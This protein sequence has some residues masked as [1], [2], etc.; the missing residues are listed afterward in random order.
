LL[1]FGAFS[2]LLSVSMYATNKPIVAVLP[3]DSYDRNLQSH[4]DALTASVTNALQKRGTVAVVD[5]NSLQ[6]IFAEAKLSMTGIVDGKQA[7]GAGKLQGADY[8]IIGRLYSLS[9]GSMAFVSFGWRLHRVSDGH[10]VYQS[11]ESVKAGRS[12]FLPGLDQVGQ[13]IA[14]AAAKAGELV[15]DKVAETFPIETRIAAVKEFDEGERYAEVVYLPLGP[16]DGLREDQKLW[17]GCESDEF[18]GSVLFFGNMT[19]E[20]F[21]DGLTLAEIKNGEKYVH[22]DS[23]NSTEGTSPYIVRGGFSCL[24]RTDAFSISVLPFSGAADPLFKDALFEIISSKIL[25]CQWFGIPE[26]GKVAEVI[27]ERNLQL[28]GVVAESEL[29]AI[30]QRVGADAV[31]F[32]DVNSYSGGLEKMGGAL[33]FVT[34]FGLTAKLVEA[35]T[36]HILWVESIKGTS[37]GVD[38]CHALV[39]DGKEVPERIVAALFE[40]FP[41]QGPVTNIQR[42]KDGEFEYIYIPFGYADGVSQFLRGTGFLMFQKEEL[43][44]RTREVPVAELELVGPIDYHLG[45]AKVAK[46]LASRGMDAKGQYSVRLVT[47]K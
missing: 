16:S 42:N 9:S 40:R 7:L 15:A 19:V 32:I 45:L 2:F 23:I 30:G 36:G 35:K 41:I 3:F 34:R 17:L 27:R 5:R 4:A 21:E 18:K 38:L 10:L 43:M 25:N 47:A 33:Q 12:S 6:A 39:D 8:I 22:V 44:G 13:A 29:Q 14:N 28:S 24:Q 26:R 31:M 11:F 20:K 37:W 46:Q 1:V